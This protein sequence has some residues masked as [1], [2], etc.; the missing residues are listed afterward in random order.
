MKIKKKLFFDGYAATKAVDCFTISDDCS[1]FKAF[2]GVGPL[3]E[4][5][6]ICGHANL[7]ERA[8]GDDHELG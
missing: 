1:R 8:V 5:L 2:K 4:C 7:S 3:R 6:L